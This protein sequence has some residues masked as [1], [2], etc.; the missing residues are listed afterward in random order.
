M[1]KSTATHFDLRQTLAEELIK[2]IAEGTASWQK[3][4]DPS[5]GDNTPIN[6]VTGKPYRGINREWLL[7]FGPCNGDG[8]FCTYKQAQSQGWQVRK[9]SHGFPVEKWTTLEQTNIDEDTGAISTNRRMLARHYTVFHASQ[10]DGIPPLEA[11]KTEFQIEPDR[12]VDDLIAAL[13]VT[14]GHG[15]NRAFYRPSDDHIQMPPL[16][17]FHCAADYDTVRLHEA[18][19]A[20]GHGS[21][22]RR[23]LSGSFG[24]PEYAAEELRAEIAASMS[25]RLLGIAFEPNAVERTERSIEGIDNTAAYLLS[26][27]NRLPERDRNRQLLQAI[28]EAQ[29]ISDYL[30]NPI[31]EDSDDSDHI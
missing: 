4:W 24:S 13:G 30:L 7:I 16:S 6:A 8:R 5:Q 17:V 1:A 14:L 12:R 18:A 15:G 10:I 29:K 22:L 21:R 28:A 23:D 26:W 25:A 31:A 27:L 11:K 3:P 2:R 19:H 9:G 20:T